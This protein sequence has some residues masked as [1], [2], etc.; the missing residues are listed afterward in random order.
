[1]DVDD[2]DDGRPASIALDAASSFGVRYNV[3]L[4]G[5]VGEMMLSAL[6]GNPMR[7]LVLAVMAVSSACGPAA[8]KDA[9]VLRASVS[10]GEA[11][12]GPTTLV[13]LSFAPEAG[14]PAAAPSP[15]R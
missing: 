1:V 11:S 12:N 10:T 15:A 6:R 7:V 8:L 2:A 5:T 14:C 9:A 4:V 3:G 13:G